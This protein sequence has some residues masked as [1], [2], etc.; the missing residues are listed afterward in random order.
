MLISYDKLDI[1]NISCSID[2]GVP[3]F[4]G[5]YGNQN[6]FFNSHNCYNMN[7]FTNVIKEHCLKSN[8]QQLSYS[9]YCKNIACLAVAREHHLVVAMCDAP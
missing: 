3:E 5:C 6:Y 9:M 1:R 7:I 4:F 8:L 2:A